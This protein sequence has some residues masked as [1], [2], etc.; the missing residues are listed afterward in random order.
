MY[1]SGLSV[2]E[3]AN[4]VK[5]HRTTVMTH[6]R[7]RG[8]RTRANVRKLDDAKAKRAAALYETGLSLGLRPVVWCSRV[9]RFSSC[10][11]LRVVR[12]AGLLSRLRG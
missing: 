3:L 6:L 1:A 7:R 4:Q 2:N 10:G 9:I 8:V 12:V 11:G 5:I